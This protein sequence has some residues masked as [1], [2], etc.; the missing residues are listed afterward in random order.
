MERKIKINLE[1]IKKA[2]KQAEANI[3]FE[4]VNINSH[5]KSIPDKTLTKGV[6]N[7]KRPLG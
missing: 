7:D 3:K 6:K 4:E 5:N 2:I 1:Q